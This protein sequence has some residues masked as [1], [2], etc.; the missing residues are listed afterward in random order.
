[1]AVSLGVYDTTGPVEVYREDWANSY[2]ETLTYSLTGGWSGTNLTDDAPNGNEVTGIDTFAGTNVVIKSLSRQVLNATGQVIS[3]LDYVTLAGT[4]YSASTVAFGTI[5]TNYL[6]TDYTFNSLGEPESTISPSGV[7][8]YDVYDYLGN[9]TDTWS[10]TVGAENGY[11]TNAST[12]LTFRAWVHDSEYASD[13]VYSDS[14]VSMY[15]VT[16]T[17]FD[18]DNDVIETDSY[19]DPTGEAAPRVTLYGND[20]QDRPVY[21]VNPPDAADN[22][23]YAKTTDDNLNETVETQEFLY[24]GSDITGDLADATGTST[25]HTDDTLLAQSTAFLRRSRPDLP[26]HDGNRGQRVRHIDPNH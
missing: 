1:M 26:N 9:V 5:G 15:K 24:T 19:T 3:K 18:A 4:T 10:G 23:T 17:S 12:V 6:E 21:V 16:H 20:W 11:T 14:G 8:E 13:V 2:T 7:I 25:L 22:I